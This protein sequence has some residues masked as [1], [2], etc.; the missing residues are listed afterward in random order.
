MKAFYPQMTQ[1]S[2][3]GRW[4]FAQPR[5]AVCAHL[6]HPRIKQARALRAAVIASGLG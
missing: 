4:P 2:Q 6:R 5:P 3:M 1:M